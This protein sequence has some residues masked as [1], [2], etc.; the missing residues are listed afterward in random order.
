MN[1]DT[2]Q[3]NGDNHD[4]TP[5][6]DRQIFQL[7]PVLAPP[8]LDL[9]NTGFEA[10]LV[11]C[12]LAPFY[13]IP[14]LGKLDK[15]RVEGR[16]CGLHPALRPKPDYLIKRCKVSNKGTQFRVWATGAE[17]HADEAIS[18][19]NETHVSTTQE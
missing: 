2:N 18:R 6:Q 7:N 4:Q 11:P 12:E 10:Y 13:P 5:L 3:L 19:L 9:L 17:S 14:K 15:I 1:Y 8:H 16:D